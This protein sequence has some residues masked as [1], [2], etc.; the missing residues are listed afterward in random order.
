MNDL[1]IKAKSLGRVMSIVEDWVE[2]TIFIPTRKPFAN[3]KV[4]EVG[5]NGFTVHRLS[6]YNEFGDFRTELMLFDNRAIMST[7]DKEQRN[8]VREANW[9]IPIK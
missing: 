1:K 6:N 9:L 5:E 8:A 4:L 7:T 3:A 2:F